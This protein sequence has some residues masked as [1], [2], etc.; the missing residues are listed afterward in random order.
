AN[1]VAWAAAF[2]KDTAEGSERAVKLADKAART[3]PG[4]AS[5]L[6]TYGALLY[7]SGKAQEAISKLEDATKLA[8]GYPS[9]DQIAYIKAFDLLFMAM[10]QYTPEQPKQAQETLRSAVQTMK[11]LKPDE[12]SES[13]EQSLLR[14][15]HRLEF[16]VLRQEAEQ[17]I[18]P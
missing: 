11:G 9:Q 3:S 10:A 15:W 7:R 14:V 6:N 13:P 16:K 4:N 17:L 18:K 2:A 12:Q 1:D 5:Y 8:Q